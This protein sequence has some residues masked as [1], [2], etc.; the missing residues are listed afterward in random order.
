M[1]YNYTFSLKENY[2]LG[3][4][5]R[6]VLRFTN[7]MN[8]SE[9]TFFVEAVSVPQ[10]NGTPQVGDNN[11][12]SFD[13]ENKLVNLY[14]ITGSNAH[15]RITCPDGSEVDSKP[16]WLDVAVYKQSGAETIYSFTLND[17]DVT[18]VADDKGTVVFYNK[19]RTI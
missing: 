10:A 15:V 1:N 13:A 2:T 9:T 16:D 12:N 19:K 18:D 3:R 7:T 4:Y 17:R 8:G 11:P 6:A 5:P 14:R